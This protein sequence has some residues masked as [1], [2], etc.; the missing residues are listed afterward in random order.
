M[1]TLTDRILSAIPP[2]ERRTATEIHRALDL[3]PSM[4]D[5]FIQRVP[6][7]ADHKDVVA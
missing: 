1:T 5:T 6:V 7:E 3:S 2:G 4:Q